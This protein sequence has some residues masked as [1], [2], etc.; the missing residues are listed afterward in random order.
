LRTATF[1]FSAKLVGYNTRLCC[2]TTSIPFYYSTHQAI[3]QLLL[4]SQAAG[5]QEEM[6]SALDTKA[7]G[8]DKSTV[9]KDVY[10]S[11]I[12][13][14]ELVI[15]AHS[16]DP[17]EVMRIQ[18]YDDVPMA[19]AGDDIVVRVEVSTST[20]CALTATCERLQGNQL[21]RSPNSLT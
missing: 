2:T 13:N 15:D 12:R 11:D 20:L 17:F 10:D 6:T 5:F 3:K 7:S 1:F 8:K 14:A 9:K 19:K 18:K 4:Y 16:V 21:T